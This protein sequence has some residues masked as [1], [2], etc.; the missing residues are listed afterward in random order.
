MGEKYTVESDVWSLGMSLLEMATGHF[1]IP[2][3]NLDQ[4]LKPIHPPPDQPIDTEPGFHGQNMAIFELLAHIVEGDPPRLP[5]HG[6]FSAD[7]C[8]FVDGWCVYIS[9]VCQPAEK[10]ERRQVT[11]VLTHRTTL[12]TTAFSF[13]S[14]K[15]KPTDRL[16]LTQLQEH[17]WIVGAK[18]LDMVA[19]V[20][21]TMVPSELAERDAERA[22]HAPAP[23]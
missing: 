4:P 9:V 19:W 11:F 14:L 18:K 3:E 12:A 1:P 10:R 13:C 20:R 16:T 22:S 21:G 7:F 17:S 15:K 5:Q 23:R 2:K 6:G 8:N